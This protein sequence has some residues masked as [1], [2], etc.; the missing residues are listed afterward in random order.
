VCNLSPL[1]FRALTRVR[2][3]RE[4][5]HPTQEP[6]RDSPRHPTRDKR[7]LA[8]PAIL[9]RREPV[10]LLPRGQ[11]IL[12]PREP[13]TLRPRG[14]AILPPRGPATLRP[15]D[16]AI[17]P[18][19]GQAIL[20]RVHRAIRPLQGLDTLNLD[21]ATPSSAPLANISSDGSTVINGTFMITTMTFLVIQVQ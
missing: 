21:R 5:L 17:L 11:A 15:R 18:P 2:L 20:P 14:P 4:P 12:L 9:L 13:A 10:T 8:V 7:R 1:I 19:R 3:A 6:I 16:P